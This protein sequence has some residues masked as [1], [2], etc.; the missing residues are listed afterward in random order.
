[1]LPVSRSR[2]TQLPASNVKAGDTI[3]LRQATALLELTLCAA[4]AISAAT[5][6][7]FET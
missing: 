6:S 1:M 2:L 4:L 5:T 7:G 3:E